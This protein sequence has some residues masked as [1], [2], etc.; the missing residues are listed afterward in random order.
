MKTA[1]LSLT[2]VLALFSAGCSRPAKFSAMLDGG[3]DP[4][5]A[6]RQHGFIVQNKSHG[7][8][9]QMPE[10]KYAY[11]SWCGIIAGP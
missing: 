8:S 6:F 2:T 9:I 10:S 5:A 3:F 4:E 7:D 1:L 11:K